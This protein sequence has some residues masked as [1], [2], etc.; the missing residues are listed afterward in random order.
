MER[1]RHTNRSLYSLSYEK[2]IYEGGKKE[3]FL[4]LK[5]ILHNDWSQ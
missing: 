4:T 2:S 1:K 3:L 5:K